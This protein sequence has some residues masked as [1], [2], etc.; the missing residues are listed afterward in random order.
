MLISFCWVCYSF[1]RCEGFLKK[2]EH[3]E[4]G[5]PHSSLTSLDE[6]P[7]SQSGLYGY[8]SNWGS[9]SESRGHVDGNSEW[10]W[11]RLLEQTFK[12][13]ATEICRDPPLPALVKSS[14]YRR[15]LSSDT[16]YTT[17]DVDRY[18]KWR[19]RQSYR[20]IKQYNGW[21]PAVFSKTSVQCYRTRH[22]LPFIFFKPPFFMLSLIAASNTSPT[23]FPA[24]AEHSIYRLAPISFATRSPSEALIGV[25]PWAAIRESVCW[26]SRRSVLVQTKM[27]GTFSQKWAISGYHCTTQFSLLYRI[28]SDHRSLDPPYLAR[29]TGLDDGCRRTLLGSHLCHY[30]LMVAICQSLPVRLYP[31]ERVRWFWK[32][33]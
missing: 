11:T 4:L 24:F 29:S 30:N 12:S 31:R 23:P 13:P 17:S 22:F 32:G 7:Y 27:R 21:K 10:K 1:E 9:K 8:A 26:S 20:S 14:F 19:L 5:Q 3:G 6:T 28:V 15:S 18:V 2:D 33:R 25:V 16:T